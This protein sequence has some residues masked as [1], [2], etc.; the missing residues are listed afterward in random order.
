MG[1]SPLFA[2]APAAPFCHFPLPNHPQQLG[3]I[4]EVGLI[5]RQLFRAVSDFCTYAGDPRWKILLRHLWPPFM[6]PNVCEIDFDMVAKG[7]LSAGS[8]PARA[9]RRP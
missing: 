3:N 4:D 6:A 1:L 2:P 9:G 5:D 8:P 7:V